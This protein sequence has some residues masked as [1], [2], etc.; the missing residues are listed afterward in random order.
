MFVTLPPDPQLAPMVA[1][2]WF[3]EDIQGEF[4]GQ[5]IQT[6]PIPMAVLSVNIGRPNT[7]EDGSFIPRASLLGLQSQ[8]RFWRSCPGTY[9]VMVMLTIPGLVRLFPHT[10][11]DSTD[12][13][14]DLGAIAGDALAGSLSRRVSAVF[15]PRGIA[16]LLDHWLIAR[17]ASSKAVLELHR[18]SAAHTV[19]RCNGTVSDAAE[20]A[21]VNRRQLHRWFLRHTGIGPKELAD[22][23]RLQNS[24][25][26]SQLKRGDPG[27]G[28]SDQA[29]KIR[30]WQRRLGTTPGMYEK[31]GPSSVADHFKTDPSRAEPAFYL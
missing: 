28:F 27:L 20:A 8:A 18:L 22:L 12:R 6:S 15:E 1:A 23:E 9:F 31:T 3:I 5:I 29:H 4:A 17:L 16:K 24:L 19:L 30:S 2:Y 10:G 14:L 25:R 13:I 11:P 26:S 21:N 7:S